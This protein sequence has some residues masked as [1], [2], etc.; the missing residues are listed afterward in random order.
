[1]AFNF[2]SPSTWFNQDRNYEFMPKHQ[3]RFQ[4]NSNVLEYNPMAFYKSNPAVFN[5]IDTKS[6]IAGNAKLYFQK[7][8]GTILDQHPLLTLLKNPN[9][10]QTGE[11]FIKA[12]VV[13]MSVYGT[14]HPYVVKSPGVNAYDKI[15]LTVLDNEYLD[16]DIKKDYIYQM[17]VFENIEPKILYKDS[18]GKARDK[19]IEFEQLLPIFDTTILENPLQSES[20][21]K[22]LILPI[23]NIQTALEA[24]NT[25]LSSPTGIGTWTSDITDANG[26]LQLTPQE[27]EEWEREMNQSNSARTGKNAVRLSRTP[28]KFT[29]TAPKFSDLQINENLR[30]DIL[31]IYDAF[32]LPK[33]FLASLESGSTFENQTQAYKR[34]LQ[35]AGQELIDN[36][37]NTLNSYF[38]DPT[39]KLIAKYDHLPIMQEDESIR[40]SA[41]KTKL[42]VL[43]LAL[44]SG[45]IDINEYRL[46]IVEDL[47]LGERAEIEQDNPDDTAKLLFSASLN[48]RGS[49]GGVTGIIALNTSVSQGALSRDSAVNIL[50]EVYQYERS[51]A[52]TLITQQINIQ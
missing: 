4:C 12:I 43:N 17:L 25:I 6:K 19:V 20:R 52:E 45:A 40:N 37:V 24:K 33:E 15:K 36:V 50:V 14:S 7:N 26:R 22:A 44:A 41:L 28:A 30:N 21:L 2:L 39:G 51:I 23:S 3:L 47:Q 1:M 32:N 42:E 8:D 29:N 48:L 10:Y 35:G 5:A 13:T 38:N 27:H 18:K 34:Y 49:V 9:P 16:I 46:K 11:D 31:M